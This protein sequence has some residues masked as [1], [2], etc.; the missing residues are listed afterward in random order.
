MKSVNRYA[1]L[2]PSN[3]ETNTFL[4]FS[5]GPKN[6]TRGVLIHRKIIMYT[7][8]K[9]NTSGLNFLFLISSFS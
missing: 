8:P 9:K 1:C 4:V 5:Y 7:I 6:N 2:V 3:V